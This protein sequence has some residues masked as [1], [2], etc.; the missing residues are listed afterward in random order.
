M[1]AFITSRLEYCNCQNLDTIIIICV[2]SFHTF[3]SNDGIEIL[4]LQTNQTNF[5]RASHWNVCLSMCAKM[6][7][8]LCDQELYV[9][10]KA[11][12]ESLKGAG[13]GSAILSSSNLWQPPMLVLNLGQYL[14][15]HRHILYVIYIL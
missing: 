3:L 12:H 9:M 6:S 15:E 2:I 13:V 5:E 11:V 4:D 10:F 14:E 1:L 8:Y 7:L